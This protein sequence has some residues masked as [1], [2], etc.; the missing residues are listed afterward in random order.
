MC[1]VSDTV[2]VPALFTKRKS[3]N[4]TLNSSFFCLQNGNAVLE[5]ETLTLGEARICARGRARKIIGHKFRFDKTLAFRVC[6]NRAKKSKTPNFSRVLSRRLLRTKTLCR[7]HTPLRHI[8]RSALSMHPSIQLLAAL[9]TLHSYSCYHVGIPFS[10]AGYAAA[11]AAATATVDS[12]SF[13]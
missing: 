8:P 10:L 3:I 7:R 9:P 4:M 1:L 2:L 5:G 13:A 12:R 6:I 11:A